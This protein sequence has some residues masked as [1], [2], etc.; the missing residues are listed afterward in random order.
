MKIVRTRGGAGGAG[1]ASRDRRAH[2]LH[3]NAAASG[4]NVAALPLLKGVDMGIAPA[5]P[6]VASVMK[7]LRA[8]KA[9]AQGFHKGELEAE[10]SASLKSG[11]THQLVQNS[12][13]IGAVYAH[14]GELVNDEMRYG[15]KDMG[16]EKVT[17]S[18]LR[19]R[20]RRVLD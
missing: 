9:Y 1:G 15:A 18:S 2:A 14:H 17:A 12:P 16:L 19:L 8:V 5:N 13:L 20:R 4:I 6:A 11:R 7:K 3:I 10:A